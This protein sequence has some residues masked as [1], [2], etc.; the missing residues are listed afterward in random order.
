MATIVRSEQRVRVRCCECGALILITERQARGREQHHRCPVCI[1][2]AFHRREP[3]EDRH[4]R[5]WLEHFTD[6]EIAY[7]ASEILGEEVTVERVRER[8]NRALLGV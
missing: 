5:Y 8:W 1:A 3:V 4:R 7:L 6:E 2:L